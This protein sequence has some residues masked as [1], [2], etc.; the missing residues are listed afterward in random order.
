VQVSGELSRCCQRMTMRFPVPLTTF[1]PLSTA[2]I[3]C[4]GRSESRQIERYLE[5]RHLRRAAPETSER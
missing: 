3:A 4:K 1:A 2:L 5:R